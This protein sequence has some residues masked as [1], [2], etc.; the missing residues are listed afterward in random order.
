MFEGRVDFALWKCSHVINII[1]L[2]C[3]VYV[4]I[5]APMYIETVPNRNSPPAILLREGWREGNKTLKRTL[6]NLSDWPPEKIQTFRRLL[7][8]EPLVSPHDLLS[9]QKTLPHGHVEAI[10]LAIHKLGLDSMISAQRC[11]ERDLVLAM[12]VERLLYPCSK[13]ATTR[14][15]HSTSLAEELGVSQATEDQLYEAMDWLLERQPRIEK[16]LAARHLQ[17]GSL[18]LYDVSSSYYEGRTC[19]LAQYGHDRDGKKGLPIIVYGLMTDGEG[20]PIAVE[21]YA[22]NTGDP[23]TVVD[24][25]NKLRER[26]HL[27]RVVLVGDRGMLTQPQIDQLKAHPQ[28]GWI[29]ALT[30]GAIR[31]LL[32]EGSLQLSLLDE[33][34]L[35]EIESPEYPGERLMV[36]YN[37][38][39][40]EERKRKREELL[41]ATEKALARIGKE[42]E[43][44][45]KKPLTATE[46]ALKVGKVLGHYKMGK[47]FAHQIED[48][49]L[50][51]S[52]R[53]ETIEQ[54]AKL[55]GIYVIRTS[56]SAEQL[57][58]ADTVRG[59]K[60][61]AQV[62]RAFRSLKGLD[63]LIRP[64]RHRTEER[65]PA[66]I[67][68]CLLAYYVEWHLRRV[69]APLLFEDE[70]LPQERRR[71]D[72]VLPARSSESAKAKKLTH[73][74][75]DGLP[76]QSFATLLSDLASRARVTYSLKTDQSGPTFQ[77][78][79]PPTPLQAKAYELLNLLPVAGN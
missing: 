47:H 50:S 71:R 72:P 61:L 51:W 16:K 65:V 66:H 57:S 7:H 58:A 67:F 76:V 63:L 9:T 11:R 46:I 34:N 52:R 59:Y 8:D 75:A 62:E 29:T 32:A 44:R 22:G 37:P 18:V 55:D 17:E 19:P 30:S 13:L 73:Q 3:F 60:S 69:W 24:Q 78:V 1:F 40:A 33:Q 42:V 36:C 41:A 54:E 20:R 35:V 28:M 38:L 10:L 23:T 26:F 77:Q 31:G 70:E 25:V 48:K 53:G 56:E 2:D 68:L 14:H 21:V 12:I 74:T 6:A 39:L 64:I 4:C 49:K 45:K 43:R 27:S 79:P 15:W 5:I